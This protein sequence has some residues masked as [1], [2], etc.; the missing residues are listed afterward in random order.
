MP[1]PN[2][3]RTGASSGP[4]TGVHVAF[5]VIE[6]TEWV[7]Q[8]GYMHQKGGNIRLQDWAKKQQKKKGAESNMNQ[9]LNL[10]FNN[11]VGTLKS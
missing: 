5:V 6:M 4:K 7:A 9:L 10:K 3:F 2:K 8:G 1:P 11:S